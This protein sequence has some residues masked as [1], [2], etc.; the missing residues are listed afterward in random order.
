MVLLYK[1]PDGASV[2]EKS[3]VGSSVDGKAGTKVTTFK[4]DSNLES[5]VTSLQR[6]LKERD[7]TIVQLRY[8]IDTMKVYL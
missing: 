8:E 5:K 3:R 6:M 2:F 4:A 7:D 1:D